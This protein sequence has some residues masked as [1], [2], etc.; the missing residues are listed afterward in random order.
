MALS[1]SSQ[2]ITWNRF[3]RRT[4]CCYIGRDA[5]AALAGTPA[6]VVKRLN[7]EVL[8]AMQAADVR[9]R[10]VQMD[11]E[12]VGSTPAQCDAFLRAQIETWSSIVRASGAK[13]G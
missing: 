13:T 5:G 9:E 3:A 8:K 4:R 2:I 6:A 1:S 7:A 10:I 11:I 12:P